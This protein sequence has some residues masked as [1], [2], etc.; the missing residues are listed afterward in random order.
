M[1]LLATILFTLFCISGYSQN[2]INDGSFE[3]QKLHEDNQL[4]RIA[5]FNDL[6]KSTQLVNPKLE[7]ALPI[8]HGVWYKRASNTAYIKAIVTD[9]DSADGDKCLLL[10]INNNSPQK[11]L[12]EWKSTVIM[13][14]LPIQRD[15]TYTITFSAKSNIDCKQLF[16]G[17]MTGNGYVIEGS[18]WVSIDDNWQEYSITVDSTK[19][20]ASGGYTN[21]LMKKGAVMIGMACEY[22][23]NGKTKQTSALIDNVVVVKGD[24]Q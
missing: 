21:D 13:Q 15:E 14:F 2:L 17:M 3:N 12:D 6:G 18:D 9:S 4:A 1:K 23:E 10:S 5:G 8:E 22:D 11:T 24:K 20:K 16:V 7:K 19:H